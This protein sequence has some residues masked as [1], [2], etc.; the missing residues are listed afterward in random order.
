[1]HL[2]CC[3]LYVPLHHKLLYSAVGEVLSHNRQFRSFSDIHFFHLYHFFSLDLWSLLYFD[4]LHP[5]C[6]CKCNPHMP[7]SKGKKKGRGHGHD[8]PDVSRAHLNALM[9]GVSRSSDQATHSFDEDTKSEVSSAISVGSE[10]PSD[11]GSLGGGASE[12]VDEAAAIEEVEDKVKEAIDGLT[13][14]SVK[15]R[16]DCLKT[17]IKAFSTCDM[18]DL[19]E[20]CR[21]TIVDALEKCLKRGKGEEQS[22]AAVLVAL[23][24]IQLGTDESCES[25]FYNF[26]SVLT[27]LINDQSGSLK[28]RAKCCEALGVYCFV[29]AEGMTDILDCM[30][31]F[32]GIFKNSY[33]KGDGSLPVISPATAELHHSALSAW[34]LLLSVCPWSQVSEFVRSHLPRMPALLESSDVA[35]RITAGETIALLYEILYNEDEEEIASDII[36]ESAL[37]NRLKML[38]TDSSK[39]RA[40][41][42]RRQQRSSFRDI[43]R[44]VEEGQSPEDTIKFGNE[45][46][47]IDTWTRKRQYEALRDVVGT[48]MNFHL[49]A[50]EFLRDVFELGPALLEENQKKSSKGSH[51]ERHLY[52]QAMFK[53]RTKVRGKLRDKR[54]AFRT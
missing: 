13:E 51:F 39:Y 12:E 29:A 35:I 23:L 37:C 50:N 52:N 19:L 28:G 16:Q 46:L 36:D 47:V 6:F 49:K 38:A 8:P 48:G 25:M 22:L 54:T 21:D 40:K 32:E 7:R 1:M 18:E 11:N 33:V 5:T 43:L 53:A 44:T 45:V 30:K 3:C 31:T 34:G 4:H 41:K 17:I 27:P 24:S 14:K 26:K 2:Y 20:N 9:N 42:D 15:H 10:P